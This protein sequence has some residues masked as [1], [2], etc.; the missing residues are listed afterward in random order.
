V[1]VQTINVTI[2]VKELL[3][4]AMNK[5]VNEDMQNGTVDLSDNSAIRLE[6]VFSRDELM[7]IWTCATWLD[8]Q[9]APKP[10]AVE[11]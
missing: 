1:S 8:V 7:R 11:A 3:A 2:N 10:E 9:L 5:V 6:G 4:E